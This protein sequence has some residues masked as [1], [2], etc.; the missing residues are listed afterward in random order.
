MILYA[1]IDTHYLLEIFDRLKA[2]IVQ[3]A[4]D[5]KMDGREA[6]NSV[7]ANSK[8]VTQ[9]LFNESSFKDSRH[10]EELMMRQRSSYSEK[11]CRALERLFELRDEFAR[12]ED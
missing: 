2:D 4:I 3:Q 10:F 8:D 11:R 12:E 9:T 1:K 7:F 6:L 5:N